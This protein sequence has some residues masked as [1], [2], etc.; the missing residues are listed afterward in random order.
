MGT[1]KSI[2]YILELDKIFEE[3]KWKEKENYEKV[4]ESLAGFSG[5]IFEHDDEYD[6]VL[7]LLE[8]YHWISLN[9][10]YNTCRK[11]LSDLINDLNHRNQNVYVF[12]IIKR[13][14]E[15]KIKSGSF[16]TYL[17]KSILPTISNSE[18]ITFEDVNTFNEIAK[19]RFKKSNVYLLVD[20]FIGSGESLEDCLYELGKLDNLNHINLKIFTIAI[21]KDTLVKFTKKHKIYY[22]LEILKG[23]T[24]YN[25]G[26]DVEKKKN[27]MR[28]I[29][30]RIFSNI[31]EYSLGYNESESLIALL[32]TPDNTF[33][34]FWNTYKKKIK[35]NP[36][37]P[38]YEKA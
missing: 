21:T 34:I 12:P 27:L 8:R 9:D 4:Y 38:R 20:D 23:I 28:N 26:E 19:L 10:Y 24:D 22:G 36:P 30:K 33:P 37:F 14:H 3:K 5:K 1:E 16:I 15:G 35:H 18:K 25:T 6:L 7:E 17:L 31:H 11:L 13:R 2:R 32:R 29:E